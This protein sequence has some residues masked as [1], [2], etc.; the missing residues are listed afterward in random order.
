MDASWLRRFAIPLTLVFWACTTSPLGRQQLL[1]FPESEVA[2]M[3]AAAFQRMKQEM[4]VARA[5][6]T[7]RY[8]ECITRELAG[9]LEGES[10]TGWQVEIFQDE[11]ANAFALPG[12]KIG[13]HTG[14]LKIATTPDQLATVLSHEI[15]HVTAEH[16]NERLSTTTVAQSG[17]SAV[18]LL[19]GG[20]GAEHDQ[21]MG[22]LGLGAQVG[23]LLPFN[24]AQESEADL[25][26]LRLMARAGF[27][28][29]A[30]VE[31]WQKM[32]RNAQ[33]SPPEFLSTHPSE[34]SRIARLQ[35]TMREVLPVYER[36]VAS[37]RRPSCG[38]A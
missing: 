11:S 31:L 32:E 17:L 10:R 13:V 36:A 26:G 14:M 3:G 37:G 4:P 35:E 16:T 25:L 5:P 1:L 33:G 30:S 38:P 8:V 23:V 19:L 6:T 24:R 22:L 18:Q 27:D 21:L 34:A 9:A 28:P 29:R 15:S 20:S 12:G 7:Q 2:E